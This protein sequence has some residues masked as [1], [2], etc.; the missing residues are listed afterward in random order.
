MCSGLL[1]QKGTLPRLTS[2]SQSLK[3]PHL[4]E[5]ES[6]YE[7]LERGSTAYSEFRC[8]VHP[9]IWAK[10]QVLR[11]RET[12]KRQGLGGGSSVMGVLP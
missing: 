10:L 3:T 12:S 1:Q 7:A 5:T 2:G 9:G 6:L 8:Y 4:A 11:R